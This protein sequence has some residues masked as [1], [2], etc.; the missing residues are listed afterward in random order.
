MLIRPGFYV[1]RLGYK[2]LYV[3]RGGMNEWY[4]CIMNP[5]EPDETSASE[6]FDLYSFRLAASQYFKGGSNVNV[7]ADLSKGKIIVKK[8]QKKTTTAG[9]C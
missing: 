9:G 2:N 1:A 6:E 7:A 5:S 8:R 3:L 4:T